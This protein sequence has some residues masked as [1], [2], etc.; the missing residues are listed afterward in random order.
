M[1]IAVKLDADLARIAKQIEY[2]T[3]VKCIAKDNQQLSHSAIQKILSGMADVKA[4]RVEKY[5]LLP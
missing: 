4:G 3:K 2:R 1:G 5:I